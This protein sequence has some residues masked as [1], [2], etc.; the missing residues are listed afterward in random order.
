MGW[1]LCHSVLALLFLKVL[2]FGVKGLKMFG[3]EWDGF[4]SIRFHSVFTL[5]IS[6][7]GGC[8]PLR[9]PHLCPTFLTGP[10]TGGFGAPCPGRSGSDHQTNQLFGCLV[11]PASFDGKFYIFY[12]VVFFNA[13]FY[14]PGPVPASPTPM[15]S[16]R[17]ASWNLPWPVGHL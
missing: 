17:E 8:F 2:E 7:L 13:F 10:D 14:K 3:F 11:T 4:P 16:C 1:Y 9:T 15:V 6:W 12:T 5:L